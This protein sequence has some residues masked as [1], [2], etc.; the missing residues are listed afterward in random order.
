MFFR[1]STDSTTRDERTKGF[2]SALEKYNINTN[3]AN[4]VDV[5]TKW[6][7]KADVAT[8]NKKY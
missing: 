1:E 8:S 4:I 7:G 5:V 6:L 3:D 2:L